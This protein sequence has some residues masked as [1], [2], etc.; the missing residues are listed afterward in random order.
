M[1]R[2]LLVTL[3]AV[4]ILSAVPARELPVA[5]MP[6]PVAP[7]IAVAPM[8][9]VPGEPGLTIEDI[10]L[11]PK[12]EAAL[13]DLERVP[14]VAVPG[15]V[16]PKDPIGLPDP[17]RFDPKSGL[18]LPTAPPANVPGGFAPPDIR[19]GDPKTP[20]MLPS[21]SGATKTKL[22]KEYG[23]TTESEKAVSLGLAW[24]ARQQ[25]PDGSWAFDQGSKEKVV[26]ATGL[27]LLPFLGAGVTHKAKDKED[28]GKYTKTVSAGLAYLMKQCPVNGP[29]AGR[30]SADMYEQGIATLALC[31]AYGMTKDPVLKPHAQAAVN[32]IQKA[33]S[34]NGSWGYGAGQNG[35]TSILGWQVQALF[36]A[37]QTKDL[38]VDERV[39]K[40]AVQFLDSVAAGARK[41]TYGYSTSAG[42]Q[43]GTALTAVGLW[44][45]ACIDKWGPEHPG[46]AEGVTG[47]MKN[48][49]AG[50]GAMKNLYYYHYAT[51][52]VRAAGGD[53]WKTWNEGPKAADGTRKGGMRDW[54]VQAQVRK[55]DD[56][57][58]HG[59]WDPEIGWFGQSCGR[60]GTTAVCVLQLEVY[61]RYLPL[62]KARE[63]KKDDK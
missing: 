7:R 20:G 13:P 47:L 48:P 36:A 4:A 24:L 53:E 34:A 14:K 9:H 40:K 35:D 55:E 2:F 26:A 30:L 8:P 29:N 6:R 10:G 41:A 18:R 38:V 33:Q 22:L 44:S 21:R 63:E 45:R 56:A 32:F 28:E 42:A 39:I 52:V 54:L 46:M 15:P 43:P 12:I 19:P 31:E 37:Q 3:A 58:K 57:T 23:G 27:A 51:Q 1:S 62:F 17:P 5:P 61:Y 25:K 49:P 60:L 16:D 59:S 50:K 11:D